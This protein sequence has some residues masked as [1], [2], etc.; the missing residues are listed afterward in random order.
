MEP[1]FHEKYLMYMMMLSMQGFGFICAFFVAVSAGVP[2]PEEKLTISL[3]ISVLSGELIWG[4]I[5]RWI[6]NLKR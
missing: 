4:L 5:A 3:A 1:D 6:I 2:E